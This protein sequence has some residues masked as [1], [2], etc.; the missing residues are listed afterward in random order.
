VIS[1][2][3]NQGL[4][5]GI[6]SMATCD[7]V[8]SG[9]SLGMHIAIALK[10]F[11]IAWFGPTVANEI[12]LYGRGVKVMSQAECGPCWKRHCQKEIMCYDLVP[13]EEIIKSIYMEIKKWELSNLKIST[14]IVL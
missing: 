5:D 8:I 1:S 13:L 10:K 12:E 2:P 14:E 3:C 6:V 4:R 9:D 7:L 11:V